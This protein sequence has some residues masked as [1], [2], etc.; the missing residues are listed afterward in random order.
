MQIGANIPSLCLCAI[1]VSPLLVD[2]GL[3]HLT[4]PTI[5]PYA[6][7][8]YF[9]KSIQ[10]LNTM[11]DHLSDDSPVKEYLRENGQFLLKPL[12]GNYLTCPYH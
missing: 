10:S 12:Q 9:T 8:I 2:Q 4:I 5:V 3:I 6:S 1:V 7:S 11:Y